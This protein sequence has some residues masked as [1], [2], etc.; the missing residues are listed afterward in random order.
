MAKKVTT[1]LPTRPMY[2]T[3]AVSETHKRRVAGYARVST[4][5]EEQTTS[6]QAQM[7]YYKKYITARSDWEFVG[8]Y[9]D[10]GI[11]ATSINHRAGFKKMVEDAMAGKIDLIITKSVSRFARNTVDSLTTVRKLKER[12]IEVFFE[13]ENIWTLDAKGELLITI[14]SSL[15]Q[16]ESRSI[17]ENTAW[18][19]RK[20]FAEGKCSVGYGAFLGYDKDFKVNPEQAETVRLIYELF[21]SGMS[22]HT[23]AKE[24]EKRGLL[25]PAGK[26]R[27]YASTVQSILTNEKYCGDARLQKSFTVDFLQRK[28]KDNEGELPQYYVEQH[29]EAIIEPRIFKLVQAEIKKR[30]SIPRYSG[31]SKYSNKIKCGVCGGWFGRKIWGSNTNYRRAVYRCNQKYSVKGKPCTSPHVLEEDVP[32]I[33]MAALDKIG[34][35]STMENI[36]EMI[37]IA[38]DVGELQEKQAAL[39]EKCKNNPEWFDEYRVVT[40]EMERRKEKK[41]L[42]ELLLNNIE[43]E[44]DEKLWCALLDYIL[45]KGPNDYLVVFRGGIEVS[46]KR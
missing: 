27:W 31:T 12:G 6:Y 24:L 45:V 17:S 21:L 44:F 30:E 15:A 28:R 26:K 46:V 10:E 20:L 23:V 19:K 16:E 35:E 41:E 40:T 11:S 5:M 22:S 8:M 34:N 18:G 33:F 13:K 3:E 36:R 25:S 39:A 42:L 29:H 9:S 7:K 38:C 14:M 43:G 2:Q 1:I 37:S 32:K 4:D